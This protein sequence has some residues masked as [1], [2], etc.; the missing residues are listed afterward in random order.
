MNRRRKQVA[1]YQR[2]MGWLAAL[3]IAVVAIAAFMV[4]PRGPVYAEYVD[5]VR[6]TV[7]FV[8]SDPTIHHPGG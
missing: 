4:W 3:G 5:G 6:P 7:V 1:W 2:S 8:W